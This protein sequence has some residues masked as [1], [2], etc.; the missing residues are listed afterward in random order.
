MATAVL[1]VVQ[2]YLWIGIAVAVVFVIWGVGRVEPNARGA[3]A[4]RPLIVPGVVL[5]WP[6]VLWRWRQVEQG[7]DAQARHRPPRRAQDRVAVMLAVAIPL[8]LVAGLLVRQNGPLERP[9]VLLEAAEA[10][11]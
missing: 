8:I 7:V 10:S 2:G 6:L 3:W 1:G 5:I 4:F 11:Q 9:A